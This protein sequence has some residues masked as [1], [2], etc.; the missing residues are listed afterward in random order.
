[1][2]S[3]AC[4]VDP[5]CQSEDSRP[6]IVKQNSTLQWKEIEIDKRIELLTI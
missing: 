2:F 4:L 3:S 6:D 5:T 1:M